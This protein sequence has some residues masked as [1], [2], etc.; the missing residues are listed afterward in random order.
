MQAINI[1]INIRNKNNSSWN[2]KSVDEINAKLDIFEEK[3]NDLEMALSNI[4]RIEDRGKKGCKNK[5]SV[6][7]RHGG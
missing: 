3:W 4:K 5:K 2:K 6:V 1:S 7:N